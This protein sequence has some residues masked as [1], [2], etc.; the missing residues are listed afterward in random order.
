MLQAEQPAEPCHSMDDRQR[1]GIQGYLKGDDYPRT[2]YVEEAP[3]TDVPLHGMGTEYHQR[4]CT[5]PLYETHYPRI[6]PTSRN[7]AGCVQQH[8]G[9]TTGTDDR[10]REEA[11]MAAYH[12][13]LCKGNGQ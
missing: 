5:V 9:T 8:I 2:L 4:A 1:G 12:V 7:A 3:D 11:V 13:N 10:Q 6:R